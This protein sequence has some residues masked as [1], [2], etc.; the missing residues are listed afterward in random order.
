MN[1]FRR[2]MQTLFGLLPVR[3]S[4]PPSEDDMPWRAHEEQLE[5]QVVDRLNRIRE[6]LALIERR[7]NG[8][9]D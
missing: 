8:H 9:H 2:V 1:N 6:S 4:P 3:I 7:K 5:Q